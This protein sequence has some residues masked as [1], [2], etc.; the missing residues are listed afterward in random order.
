[1]TLGFGGDVGPAARPMFFHPLPLALTVLHGEIPCVVL[2]YLSSNH[3]HFHLCAWMSK[4][5]RKSFSALPG[6]HSQRGW[7]CGKIGKFSLQIAHQLFSVRHWKDKINN[8]PISPPKRS[9]NKN[10]E[11]WTSPHF[12]RVATGYFKREQIGS[13]NTVLQHGILG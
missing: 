13:V 1:M 9:Q 4:S 2:I 6:F 10:T 3:G 12:S 7:I 11:I 8:I 5:N